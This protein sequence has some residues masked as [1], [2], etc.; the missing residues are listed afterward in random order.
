MSNQEHL[1][2]VSEKIA[3]A[4]LSFWEPLRGGTTFHMADLVLHVTS[5]VPNTAPDSSS[6]VL[7]YLRREGKLL[8]VVVDRR[9]SLYR[10][11]KVP[12]VSP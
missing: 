11:E 2:R 6:R 12:R 3:S 8:Y 4:I 1:D 10:V 5:V 7:R 9:A